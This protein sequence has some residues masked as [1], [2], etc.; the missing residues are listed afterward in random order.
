MFD[1]LSADTGVS[2]A[3]YTSLGCPYLDLRTPMARLPAGCV[4]FWEAVSSE[5]LGAPRSGDI[6]FLPSLRMPRF[7]SGSGSV[8]D[9]RWA[10][11][12]AEEW[13]Q[14]FLDA[15]IT[16]L[17]E[18]PKPL[19]E[20][21]PY[22]CSDWFNASNPRCR[23]L[24]QSRASLET[25]RQPVVEAMGQLAAVRPQVRVWDPFPTLCPTDKCSAVD[26]GRPLFLD[27]DHVTGYGNALLY[28]SFKEA[29][30]RLF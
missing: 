5:V 11:A 6:L 21:A 13:L 15:R 4:H 16:V 1:R 30:T 26:H 8:E 22:R 23:G 25:L 10:V 20:S 18:A 17:F 3:V 29:V 14:P 2:V 12:E 7:D 9:F 28:P 24:T 19:F 27:T